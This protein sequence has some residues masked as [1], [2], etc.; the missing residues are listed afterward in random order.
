MKMRALLTTAFVATALP[1]LAIAQTPMPVGKLSIAARA[2]LGEVDIDRMQGQPAKLAW[3]PD[4][5]ELYLQ[6]IEGDFA[7]RG[8]ARHYVYTVANGTQKSVDAEPAWANAYWAK[9]SDR[10]LPGDPT[11]QIDVTSVPRTDR[12]AS[13]PMG[14][15]LARGGM[16][17]GG[18]IGG[19]AGGTS[20]GDAIAA[21]ANQQSVMVHSL[22]FAGEII[23]EFVNAVP[24]PGLT[25]GWGPEGSNVIVFA[26]PK[27]GKL[28]IMNKAKKKQDVDGTKDAILPAFSEDG[29]KLAWL[30]RDGRKKF[31]LLVADVGAR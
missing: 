14:G 7:K 19:G 20:T 3:S 5:S 6:V 8:A 4:G 12:A 1:A 31:S 10:T 27:G 11:F 21:A 18:D 29:S 15:D 24:V 28:V 23:G 16:G 17:G 9:K 25:F 13:A 22:K 30:R 2:P 26:Q